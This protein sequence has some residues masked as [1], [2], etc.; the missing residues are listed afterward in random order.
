MLA[1][2]SMQI[3]MQFWVVGTQR[4]PFLNVT[5]AKKMAR[6]GP[7]IT[8][9][10]PKMVQDDPR[11]AQDSPRRGQNGPNPKLTKIVRGFA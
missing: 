1:K 8:P 3:S 9:R 7:K 6:K 5:I 10:W 4:T 11:I 2:A